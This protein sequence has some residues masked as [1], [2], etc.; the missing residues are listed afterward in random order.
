V[1]AL[2]P[3]FM[4]AFVGTAVLC[5][6]VIVIAFTAADAPTGYLVAGALAYIGGVFGLTLA[7]NVPLNDALER[8]DHDAPGA[9]AAWREY[10]RRWAIGNHVRSAAGVVAGGLMICGLVVA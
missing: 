3:A 4:T 10:G 8:R 6:V 5:A 7:Y 9:D 2:T 1:V